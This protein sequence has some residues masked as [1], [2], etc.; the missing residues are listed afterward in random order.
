[1]SGIRVMEQDETGP[2][3]DTN[4]SNPLRHMPVATAQTTLAYFI[5]HYFSASKICPVREGKYVLKIRSTKRLK[6]R[7]AQYLLKNYKIIICSSLQ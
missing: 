6:M 2:N 4:L 1:M 7:N 3:W 5:G